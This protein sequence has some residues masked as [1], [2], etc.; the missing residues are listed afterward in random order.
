MFRSRTFLLIFLPYKVKTQSLKSFGRRGGIFFRLGLTLRV[1]V[2]LEVVGEAMGG[3]VHHRGP[4]LLKG[5]DGQVLGLLPAKQVP[6]K[7]ILNLSYNFAF[8]SIII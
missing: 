8:L 6:E 2:E 3:H 7:F 5:R 1:L 4:V